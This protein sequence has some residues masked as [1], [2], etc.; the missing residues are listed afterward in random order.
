MFDFYYYKFFNK[1]VQFFSKR[2]S[3]YNFFCKGYWYDASLF[4][5]VTGIGLV[6]LTIFQLYRGCQFYWWRKLEY[7]EKTT[8]LSQVTDKFTMLY[9]V[10]HE[11]DLNSQC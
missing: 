11:Q 7:P 3:G 10:R 9:R 2:K 1:I 8:D 5:K 6:R 4:E